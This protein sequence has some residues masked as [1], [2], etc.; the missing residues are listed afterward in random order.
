[1]TE[2]VQAQSS[3]PETTQAAPQPESNIESTVMQGTEPQAETQTEEVATQDPSQPSLFDETETAMASEDRPEWL[4]EKFKAPEDLAKSYDE[5]SR[6]LG[7]HTGAPESYEMEIEAGLEE[8]ALSSEDPFATD[9]AKVLK[10]NGVNQK[11]YNEIAN[12]YAAKT[13]ADDESIADAQEH[14]FSEDCK[15]LGDDRVQE[16]KDSIKWARDIIDADSFELLKEIGA[17]DISVGLLV[18]QFHDAY[19]NKNY[20]KMPENDMDITDKAALQERYNKVLMDPRI[21][22]D[23]ILKKEADELCRRLHF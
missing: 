21:G 11:T 2:A 22:S 5:L 14:Q 7:A 18:K 9:F 19:T 15:E 10:E 20:A 12:L 8:Y 3:A 1:M 6:K 16:I 17:K 13:R 23:P 4:P